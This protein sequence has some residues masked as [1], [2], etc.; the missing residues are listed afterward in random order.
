[1]IAFGLIIAFL[2]VYFLLYVRKTKNKREHSMNS[3]EQFHNNYLNR[4]PNPPSKQA[5]SRHY[6][7]NSQSKRDTYTKYVT[8]YNSSEDY[9][10]K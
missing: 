5:H 6:I 7:R 4:T 1:M 10:E 2:L 9:R 8:K 3:V